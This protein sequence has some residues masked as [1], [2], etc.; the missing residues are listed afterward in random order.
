MRLRNIIPMSE[1]VRAKLTNM[2][3]LWKIPL[4]G[5]AMFAVWKLDAKRK[6][7]WIAPYLPS[8]AHILEIGS[9][10]GSVLSLLR[11][12]GRNVTAVDVTDTSYNDTLQPILYDGARLPYDDDSFDVALLLTVLHHTHDPDAILREAMRVAARV[13]VIEDI[14]SSPLQR[15]LTK[16]TDAIINLEF[17]DHPH[18]NRDDK[19]WHETFER[20]GLRITHRSEKPM[21]GY[22]RQCLYVLE[23]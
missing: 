11:A 23:R 20:L 10:P 22:F 7:D 4:F 15:R 1:A 14:Y 16:V 2:R 18:A 5:P 8:R 21:L 13:L 17:I 3:W 12:D 6:R 19:G 9:G